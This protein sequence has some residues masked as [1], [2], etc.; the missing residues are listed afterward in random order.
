M[1]T[2]AVNKKISWNYS[3]DKGFN[4][5]NVQIFSVQ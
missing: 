3:V 5:E 1:T 4:T 2:V